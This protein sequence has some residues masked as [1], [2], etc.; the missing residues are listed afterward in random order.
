M[1]APKVIE[2][3]PANPDFSVMCWTSETTENEI[4][5]ALRKKSLWVVSYHSNGAASYVTALSNL[6]GVFAPPERTTVDHIRNALEHGLRRDAFNRLKGIIAVSAEEL[7]Q[8][9]R[10]PT[11]TVARRDLFKPD[12]S[13]RLLRVA[14]VFQRAIEVLGSLEGARRWFS[15]P[16]RALNGKSPIEYCDTEPGADAVANLLGRID[17]GVF[18]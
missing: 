6:Q 18:T 12:E 10:I 15:G 16:K 14:S 4:R 17:H 2:R 13:E 9:V 11:R 3:R 7:S 1:A 8:V 5:A